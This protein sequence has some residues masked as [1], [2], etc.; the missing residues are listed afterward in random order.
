MRR[1]IKATI[2]LITIILLCVDCS[3][4]STQEQETVDQTAAEQQSV[5]EEQSVIQELNTGETEEITVESSLVQQINM[6]GRTDEET[7]LLQ[8]ILEENNKEFQV[9]LIEESEIDELPIDMKWIELSGYDF[10]GDGQEEILVSKCYGY[11]YNPISY[12]Y[13]YDQ[14][15]EKMLEFVGSGYTEIIS[16]WDGDGTFL[17][18]DKNHYGANSNANIYTEI[19]WENGVLEENVRLMELD[20][21]AGGY[22]G[23]EG[24][25]IFKDFTKEEEE[26]LW[27]GGT[28]AQDLTETKEY[29]LE[30]K[31]LEEYKR[32]FDTSEITTFSAIGSIYYDDREYRLYFDVAQ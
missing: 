6:K 31:M 15:G 23:K 22:E 29:V 18:Y 9:F 26:K 20:C 11:L 4:E 25:Y 14:M 19:R 8:K 7:K 12:H 16:E 28:G 3:G 13:V 21:R 32:L 27:Y 30:D 2:I 17:L 1:K 10:T 24:Y 5:E